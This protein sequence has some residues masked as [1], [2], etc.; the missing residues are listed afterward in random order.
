MSK[1]SWIRIVTQEISSLVERVLEDVVGE[2]QSLEE[3]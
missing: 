1:S 2:S 3:I